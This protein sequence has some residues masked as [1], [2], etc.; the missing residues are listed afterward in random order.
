MPYA[1]PATLVCDLPHPLHVCVA[2]DES[3]QWRET[4]YC[5]EKG[6]VLQH[7]LDP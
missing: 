7:C 5:S 2:G 4:A 3:V 1:V 6:Q